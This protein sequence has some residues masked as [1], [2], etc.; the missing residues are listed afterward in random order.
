MIVS[1]TPRVVR[2]KGYYADARP[3]E[4]VLKKAIEAASGVIGKL[5]RKEDDVVLDLKPRVQ[6]D[7]HSCGMQSLAAILDYYGFSIDYDEL[8]ETI[9]LTE[10][11]SDED[12]LRSAIRAYG[13][14]HKTWHRTSLDRLRACIDDEHPVLVPVNQDRHWCVVYGYGDGVVYLMNPSISAVKH[15]GK[16]SE[17]AFLNYWD[18]RWGIEVFTPPRKRRATA[19]LK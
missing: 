8:E 17:K 6:I 11:G 16:R 13:M 14:K 3:G 1:P 4:M 15:G 12:Q 19:K 10:E 7:G 18:S 5:R 9:G 2:G